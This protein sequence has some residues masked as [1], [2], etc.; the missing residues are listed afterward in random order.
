MADNPLISQITL[1]SGVTYDIKDAA[2]REALEAIAG[3]DAINFKGVSSTALTNGGTENPTV[4]SQAI[5]TKKTGDLYFYGSAEFIWDGA[6]WVELGDLSTLGDLAQYDFVNVTATGTVSQPSFSGAEGNL[7]VS[8]T[9]AGTIGIGNGTANYTP[10]GTVSQPTFSGS[11]LT[12]TGS[13]TP[14]GAISVGSGTANYTPAGTM[15][16]PTITVATAGATDTVTGIASIG[17]VGSTV[18]PTLTMA[19]GSGNDAENL[20]ITWTA[21]SHTEATWP[22]LDTEKTFKTS[23]AAY[24][25]SGTAFSGTGVDLEFGGTAA[26]ISVAGTPSGTVSQPTFSG[27]GVDLEFSGTALT[28]TGTFTPEGTVSQPTF[29]GDTVTAVPGNN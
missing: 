26:T 10:G 7:S 15:T 22:T 18:L 2:A 8:G 14:A 1:P 23:D 9:P 3:L 11:E 19:P 28:S 5:T 29:T 12:S 17:S 16:D 6:K 25:A 27:D 24:T 4:D 21:G 20:H 13:Y